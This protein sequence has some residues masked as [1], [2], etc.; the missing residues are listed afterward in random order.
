MDVNYFDVQHVATNTINHQQI[1]NS[2]ELGKDDIPE[3]LENDTSKK[4]EKNMEQYIRYKDKLETIPE[5]SDED[6]LVTTQGN[7]DDGDT[8][9]YIQGDSEDEQ[10]NTAIDDT[11]DN[12]MIILGKLLTTAF[13][14]ANVHIPT[15]KVG[16]LQVTNQLREFLIHFPL[17]SKE[18]AFKQIYE[19]LQVLNAYLIDNPQQHIHCMSPDNEY[20][21]LIMYAITIKINLCNFLAI[22]AVLSILLDTQ[23]STLQHVKSFQQVVNN[24][25]DKRPTDVISKLEQQASIIMKAMYDSINNEHSDSVS[26]D[27]DRVSGAVDSDYDVND[28]DKDENVMPYD[29]D[30]N[31][32]PY[33]KDE[34]VMPHDS[35]NDDDDQMPAKYDN[36]YETVTNKM[37]HDKNM[38]SYEQTDVGKKDVVI[39]YKANQIPTKEKR[40]IETKDIDD[41]F[42]REYDE[43]YKSMEYKQTCDYYEAQRHIQSTME[44]D[45]P[46]KTSQNRQCIDNVRDYDRE[47]NRILN[48]VR[49]TLDL[50]PNMLLGAQQYTTVESAAALSIQEKFKGKYDDNICNANGQYKNEWYK[51][52]ENMVPQL[53]GTYNVSDDSDS[54]LHSYLD[55]ASSNIIAHRTRGQKQRYETD[56]RAHTSKRLAFK[57]ST[58]PNVNINMKGQKV[59]DDENIDINKIAQGKRPKGGR[60]MADI[61]AKQHKDKEAKR[62]VPEKV[63]RIQG[64]NDS[65]NIEAKRYMIE[66]AKIEALIEKHRLRTLK[67]PDEVNKL[68]TGKNATEKGQ[69][70]TRKGKPPYKKATKDIQIKRSRKKGTE[71]TNAETGKADTLLGDSVANT[72]TGIEKEKE[73]GQKDKIGIDGIGIFEF[74]FKG[75]PE[76]PELEGID[77]DRLRDLQNAVQEQLC[78]RDEERERNVTKRVQEFEKTFDFVNLHLLKGVATM[79]E[80]TKSDSRQPM[81]KI[82]PTD[83]MV[84][85]PSLFDGTKP[86]TSK[87]HYERF[88]LYINF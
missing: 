26:G 71:A 2:V 40:P 9:P 44:G 41:A 13:V 61:T 52:A 66:K 48:S 68:G 36:D 20:V 72:A 75:L 84:M 10:F 32:M 39:Y 83:K 58:K 5:E 23:S 79:A 74:I 11:S 77:E 87:Q 65:M 55:L 34:N 1:V 45:T 25:Y 56:I 59:P 4:T 86:A 43:M 38:K 8:I 31:V 18:K 57:E 63:K 28:Y 88:I 21:S 62:L 19:I 60:N 27:I 30:E 81:G 29:K 42:M 33:D 24:Y 54:D 85:M 16:C 64:Q 82:K 15:E 3:L 14:S 6:L 69:E 17:E 46:I 22:W 47:Y 12:P 37:K 49:H 80:L 53:D 70:G 51:R 50:G 73:K 76:L 7:G 67:T 78:K 35:D